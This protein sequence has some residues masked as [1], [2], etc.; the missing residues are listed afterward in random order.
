MMIRNSLFKVL[1]FLI[2]FSCG[3]GVVKSQ[4]ITINEDP[5]I[6]ELMDK[7]IQWNKE[8]QKVQGWRIQ[9]INTDDRRKMEK[10]LNRFRTI[11]PN[12]EYVKWRQVSPYYKVI[13]G[14]YESK[15]D[16][17]AFLQDVKEHFPSA[18]AI[19]EKINKKELLEMK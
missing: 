6:A 9:I 15:L 13:I 16:V 18:I 8:N 12:I 19:I 2:V 17:L 4:H 5:A 7:Y 1:L 14:A 3:T 11:F 10:E